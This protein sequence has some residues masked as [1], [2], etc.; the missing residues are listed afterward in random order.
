MYRIGGFLIF[1]IATTWFVNPEIFQRF[2]QKSLE[3]FN[4]AKK[5]QR[6][7][8]DLGGRLDQINNF[9][10]SD[11]F[12]TLSEEE[13]IARINSLLEE[14]GNTLKL[15]EESNRKGDIAAT[16]S[17]ILQK[18]LPGSKGKEVLSPDP[19]W[20]PPGTKCYQE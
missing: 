8:E 2:K 3:L 12:P 15:I 1:V 6:L 7:I 20:L 14:S 11:E 5:E 9:I 18:I 16:G 19:T 4:P 13:K 17:N 10:N